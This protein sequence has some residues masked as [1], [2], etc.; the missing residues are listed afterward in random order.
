M[1]KGLL[2]ICL[3]ICVLRVSAESINALMLHM[4]SGKQIICM[5]DELPVVSFK[6]KELVLISRTD[7]ISYQA[8]EIVK[9]TYTYVNTTMV[10]E[11][12]K[13]S[14][15]F[16]LEDNVL[17]AYNLEPLSKVF[18]YNMDGML[19]TSADTGRNGEVTISLPQSSNS[20]FVVKTSVANFKLIKQ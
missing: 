14:T 4:T 19:I 12:R 1:K 3:L 18:I 17:C 13:L 2:L 6:G 11:T 15:M 5:L 10:G 7:I 20:V 16:K 9:F 8:D